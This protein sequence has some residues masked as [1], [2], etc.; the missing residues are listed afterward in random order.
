MFPK[1]P[2]AAGGRRTPASSSPSELSRRGFLQS[3]AV[4]AAG[5]AVAGGVPTRAAA[6][7]RPRARIAAAATRPTPGWYD[8]AKLGVFVHWNPAAI[9]AFAPIFSLRDLGDS[10][11]SGPEWVQREAWRVLPY[12]EMYE[13]TMR[14][15]GSETARYHAERYGNAPYADFVRQFRTRTLRRW[16]PAPWADVFDRSGA[17]YVVL[18]T[19][20]EDGF[21]LWPSAHRN[22][23]RRGWQAE[24]DVLG[25]LAAAVR[26]KGLRF[27]TY[28]C[29]GMDWTFNDGPI[30][31]TASLIAA[32][33][34]S[35]EYRAYCDA[36]WR[37]L[38]DR[39]Q[40]SVLW[41]DYP[42]LPNPDAAP[43][44][45]TYFDA[46]PDGV[47]N[48]RFDPSQGSGD[49]Q[50]DFVTVEYATDGPDDAKWETCRGIGTS[51]GYNQLED[52]DS[53]MSAT[54]LLY[55]FVDIVARGGN[56]LINVGP[57]GDGDIPQAQAKRLIA[58]GRWLRVNGEAIYRTRKWQRA[59]GVTTEGLQLRFTTTDEAFYATVLGTPRADAV[60]LDVAIAPGAQVSL[61]G[62]PSALAWAPSPQGA[63]VELPGRR[64]EQPALSLKVTPASAVSL[65]S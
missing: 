48:D 7:A 54:E 31:D 17:N 18:T 51:F 5:V 21:L 16:D 60:D 52:D 27:G 2:H 38:I 22:P 35:D 9:P 63:R 28:Y 23:H 34:T 64:R 56:L 12:A 43:L 36:H 13:N 41:D 46:V 40:P 14:I 49:L 8:D 37:E 53:Y 44:F 10:F 65:P 50:R 24:R 42:F 4:G 61:L 20:T 29:G 6:A 45:E 15:P 57:T 59:R 58:L 32:I 26:A 55:M 33:P 1:S 11:I 3:A 39:Y 25:E 30:A 19:K 62:G 47:V